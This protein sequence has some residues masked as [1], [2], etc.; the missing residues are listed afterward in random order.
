[1]QSAFLD[2]IR[3]GWG[4]QLVRDVFWMS[5]LL[6]GLHFVGM[7]V[8]AGAVAVVDLSVLGLIRGIPEL[9]LNGFLVWSLVG[10]GINLISGLLLFAAAPYAFA[11]N[12]AFQIK[13]ACILLAGANALWFWHCA[14]ACRRRG[15]GHLYTSRVARFTSGLS[16]AIWL[17]VIACARLIPFV[18]NA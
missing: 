13:L 1:M 16:L 4:G 10:F 7:A 5:P 3:D 8:L 6:E 17:T 14:R 2:W 11:F 15:P 12:R 18:P 9:R